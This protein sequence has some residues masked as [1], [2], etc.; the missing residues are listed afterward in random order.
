MEYGVCPVCQ[1]TGRRA[2]DDANQRHKHILAGYDSATDTLPC[3]NCGG[4]TMSIQA[5]GRVPLRADGSP[6]VH[7]YIGYQ[8][9]RCIW[10]YT[11]KHCGDRY[12]IDSSD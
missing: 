10:N 9:G 11:C 12:T 6:C 1:G 8:A 2:V 5:T 3:L 4:Q 7:E